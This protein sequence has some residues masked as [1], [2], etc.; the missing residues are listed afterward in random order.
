MGFG[1]DNLLNT[2]CDLLKNYLIFHPEM[3]EELSSCQTPARLVPAATVLVIQGEK[4][5]RDG[6]IS[7]AVA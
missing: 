5:A 2:G 4:L 7:G 3:L 1:S 6:D